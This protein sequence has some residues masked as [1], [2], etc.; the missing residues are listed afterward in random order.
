MIKLLILLEK[1]VCFKVKNI[2]LSSKAKTLEELKAV[3]KYSKVLPVYRFF[4]N[5]YSEQKEEILSQIRSTFDTNL[6]VRSSSTN[7]DNLQTSNAGGFES[8]LDVDIDSEQEISNA[9]KD[10]IS[11]YGSDMNS[12][13]EVLV[14]PMLSNVGMSGVVFT[15]DIDTLS[16][17]YIINYDESGST[18][19]VTSGKSNDLKTF[20]TLKDGQIVN[21]KN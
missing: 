9:I 10:V 13:D 16:Q 21:D 7:E 11:S 17:Y 3:V 20:I 2:K 18:S 6:I 14:Q 8:V 1:L 15:A 5:R 4:A 12:G 19:G